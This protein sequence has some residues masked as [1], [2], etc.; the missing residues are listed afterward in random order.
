MG[1]ESGNTPLHLATMSGPADSVKYLT[2]Q[3]SIVYYTYSR[4][5]LYLR[6]N[7]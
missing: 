5:Q 4:T 6:I 1:D 2:E 7:T 3:R